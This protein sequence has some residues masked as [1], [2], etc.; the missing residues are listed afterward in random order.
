MGQIVCVSHFFTVAT[1]YQKEEL[2]FPSEIKITNCW[3]RKIYQMSILYSRRT[4]I[5]KQTVFRRLPDCSKLKFHFSLSGS[6][7][8]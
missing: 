5:D 4:T 7:L 2:S 6:L 3:E 8:A 1:Q